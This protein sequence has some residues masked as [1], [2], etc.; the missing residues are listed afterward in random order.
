MMPMP[1]GQRPEDGGSDAS[2]PE[3]TPCRL[4][5]DHRNIPVK[6]D[7]TTDKRLCEQFFVVSIREKFPLC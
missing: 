5:S 6:R 2:L 4:Q 1:C 7:D 3:S